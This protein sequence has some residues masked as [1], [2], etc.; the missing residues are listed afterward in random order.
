[1]YALFQQY[2]LFQEIFKVSPLIIVLSIIVFMNYF[3]QLGSRTYTLRFSEMYRRVPAYYDV[4]RG[5]IEEC[6]CITTCI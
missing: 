1:M 4:Y 6:W 3:N 5:F 2:V